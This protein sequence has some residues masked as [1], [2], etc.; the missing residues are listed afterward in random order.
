[1]LFIEVATLTS[2]SNG[3]Y[4]TCKSNCYTADFA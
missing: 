4:F 2:K 1:M 3:L